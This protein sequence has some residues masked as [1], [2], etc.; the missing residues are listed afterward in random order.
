[1]ISVE[2]SPNLSR[3]TKLRSGQYFFDGSE[4]RSTLVVLGSAG[5]LNPNLVHISN[6]P[7]LALVSIM[8][9]H[10]RFTAES[11]L[12]SV[13]QAATVAQTAARPAVTH[14][15]DISCGFPVAPA[16]PRVQTKVCRSSSALWT[17]SRTR[18][19]PSRG[20]QAQRTRTRQPCE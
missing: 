9:P 7:R 13:T 4:L 8:M 20:P 15:A 16:A 14:T 17:H 10:N 3:G 2:A 6:A 1:M 12:D 11:R 18:F 5:L 19:M